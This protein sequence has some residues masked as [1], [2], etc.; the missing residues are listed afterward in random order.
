MGKVGKLQV[1]LDKPFYTP[2]DDVQGTVYLEL[3]EA[4]DVD[5]IYV[6]V[7]GKEKVEWREEWEEPIFE[8]VEGVRQ[9]TGH[10]E[11]SAEY[12]EKESF[13]KKKIKL[14]PSEDFEMGA[15]KY[16]FP[17]SFTLPTKGKKGGA[18][19]GSW[20]VEDGTAFGWRGTRGRTHNMKAKVEYSLK[21]VV[22][23]DDS[24]DL[25]KKVDFCVYPGLPKA[26]PMPSDAREASVMFCCC[27][28][29][30]S[31]K[32]EATL[33][34]NVY[35][36]GDEAEAVL[37]VENE[38]ALEVTAM[39]E[40]NRI[41]RMR[42]DEHQI[43][44]SR[45]MQLGRF[46]VI[47]PGETKTVHMKFRIPDT[48]PTTKAQHLECSY[49]LDIVSELQCAPD[50]ELHFPVHIYQRPID[51]S[52]WVEGLGDVAEYAVAGH[53]EPENMELKPGYA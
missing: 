32:M 53:G 30:G 24:K 4:V 41:M 34:K 1:A 5:K 12:D 28:N 49:V 7:K 35:S 22:D 6:K 9:V 33:D 20:D 8:E 26:V 11:E 17:F 37:K 52:F 23:L 39:V 45:E 29:R 48:H 18:L 16:A 25:E 44:S 13:F 51:P 36:P 42:A 46:D 27:I 50:I 3:K 10:R 40:M 15:G 2:G 19:A 14:V 47:E 21:A 38:S 43:N 31:L